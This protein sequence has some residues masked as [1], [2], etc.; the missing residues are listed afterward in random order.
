MTFIYLLNL[1]CFDMIYNKNLMIYTTVCSGVFLYMDQ[2]P[3]FT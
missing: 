3:L 2:R 1:Y